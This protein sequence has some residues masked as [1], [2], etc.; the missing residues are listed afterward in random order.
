MLSNPHKRLTEKLGLDKSNPVCSPM[1]SSSPV[2]KPDRESRPPK[3]EFDYLSIVGTLLQI[4]NVTR[5]DCDY[6][7]SALARHS[8]LRS[9]T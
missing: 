7:V 5:P 4:V 3:F 1:I 6:A 9:I 2:L 8:E